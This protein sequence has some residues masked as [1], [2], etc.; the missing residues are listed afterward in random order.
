MES[1]QQTCL[2]PRI[3]HQILVGS[4]RIPKMRKNHIPRKELT[5]FLVEFARRLISAGISLPQLQASL[6]IAFVRAAS[7]GAKLRNARLNQSALAAMTGLN[8]GQIRSIL[9]A[10]PSDSRAP[11]RLRSLVRGWTTDEEYL[12]STGRPLVLPMRGKRTSFESLVKKYGGDI[13]PRALAKELQR[14]NFVTSTS[15]RVRLKNAD[16]KDPK[17]RNLGQ[18]AVALAEALSSPHSSPGSTEL[19]VSSAHIEFETP[20]RK[21]KAILRRRATQGLQA[22]ASDSGRSRQGSQQYA[23]ALGL[24]E[25]AK[26][27]KSLFCL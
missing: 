5:P 25:N 11:D 23:K 15:H 21:G 16:P 26:C 24:T 20:T 14:Q 27:Q 4:A 7:E 10:T 6:Q 19:R 2:L 18:F 9:K 3:N 8:R 13:T 22:F 17:L 1:A 12:D